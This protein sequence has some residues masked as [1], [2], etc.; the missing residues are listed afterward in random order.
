MEKIILVD[1][2]NLLFR[3]YYATAYSGNF[4]KNSKGFPTNALYGFTNMINKIINEECPT[5]MIVA[6]DKGKTFRHEK[7]EQYKDGRIEMPDELKVQ[8]PLAKELLTNMG[9]KYY[10]CDNYEADDIIGTFAKYCDEEE[11]FI[12]TIVSSDKDLLQLISHDVDIKLLKQKDYIRY[13]EK[14]FKEAYGIEPINI[15]DLKA[16]M[17]DSSDNIP[18]V[19]GIGEKT[20]LKLLHDY[21]TLNGVYDNLDKLTPKMR[22]KLEND[23]DNAYMSYDLATIYKEV[24]MEIS[25]PDIKLKNKNSDKLNEMYKELEFYSFLKKEEKKV[26]NNIEVKIIE[27]T[28]EINVQKDSAYYLEIL[29]TNY[30]SSKILGMAIYNEDNSFYIPFQI[31]EKKHDFLDKLKYTYDYKKNYVALKKHNI[32][33]LNTNFDTMIAGYLLEYNIKEDISY[34]AN[35]F[36]YNI[37]FYDEMYLK[38]KSKSLYEEEDIKKTAKAALLKAKFIY[39]TK[40]IFE[41]KL[42]EEKLLDLFEE[43]EM[44]LSKVLGDMEYNG[45]LIDQNELNKLGEEF[46]IKIELLEQSIYNDAGEKFNIS[47]PKQLGE[48]LFDKLQLPHGKKNKS[49]YS[50]SIDVLNKL[51]GKHPIIE[52]IIEYR[53][54]NK[55][56]TTYVEGLKNAICRDGKIHTIYTQTLTRTG[57]L[58]SIEPNLQNIPIRNEYGALIRKAFIPSENGIIMSGDYSQIELRILS[59]MANIDSLKKAFYDNIDI[60]TKTASD[61]FKIPTDLVDKKMRRIA[62]AVNFGIIYG[63]SSFGLSENLH[64]RPKEAKEF[65]D[66]YLQTYPGVK[67]YMDDTIKK[68]YEDGYV[69]TLFN[70]KRTI[71]E[72]QN[73]N[74]MIRQSG[75]R[76]ALN[77]PIQGTSADIIKK[78]MIEIAKKLEQEKMQTKMI[79]QVHDELVFDVPNNEKEKIEKIIKDIMENV[80]ELSVPLNVEIAY[81]KNWR[82]AK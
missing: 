76:I 3:S 50:T 27:N 73:K 2:N 14:S 44:P 26:E 45:V 11:D 51:L 32:N 33:I 78:A 41:E 55:L 6:F 10:E 69:R 34:L 66:S 24:P 18:G 52:K 81:G 71:G 16:L 7:Y 29:G 56:Y 5:Y 1:G 31:L 36:N 43:I 72:L 15:I 25:I 23:K 58:S 12:G 46:K 28:S 9:I 13:N 4:M 37:P 38:N 47:S 65:I 8:F 39:E 74:Y 68:A 64:I 60:H 35:S 17:G 59:H 30:H 48:I 53:T 21:K 54:I 19:K 77:T 80:C 20:A 49:G 82:E 42:K 79:I 67:Q 70:R 75:E 22:E 62:K 63:I 40:N 61:I 57:R